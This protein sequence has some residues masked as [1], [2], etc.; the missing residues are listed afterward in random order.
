LAVFG[1]DT[2]LSLLNTGPTTWTTYD[3]NVV[4]SSPTTTLA[5]YGYNDPSWDAVTDV[6]VTVAVPGPIAGTGL[7]GLIAASTGLLAWWRRK[8][9]A[10]A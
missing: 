2:L 6:S 4:A 3:Y 10:P 1:S 8:R 7:P 9:S 5:F